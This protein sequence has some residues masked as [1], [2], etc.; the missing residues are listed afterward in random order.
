MEMTE[1]MVA[2]DSTGVPDPALEQRLESINME[3]DAL[4][5]EIFEIREEL[6]MSYDDIYGDEDCYEE[7]KTWISKIKEFFVK[8]R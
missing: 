1:N 3:I 4:Y 8:Q 5:D 6:G 7:E 2:H